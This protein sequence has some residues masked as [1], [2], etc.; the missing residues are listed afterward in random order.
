METLLT[1]TESLAFQS[2]LTSVD[3][4]QPPND[5]A[6][7]A[8]QF[9]PNSLRRDDDEIILD[10]APHSPPDNDPLT[11][12]T[13]DLMSL[14]APGW[15]NTSMMSGHSQLHHPQHPQQHLMYGSQHMQH[16]QHEQQHQ[17]LL[18]QPLHRQRA[19]STAHDSFPFLNQ[20]NNFQAS[21]SHFQQAP[22]HQAYGHPNQHQLNQQQSLNLTH[23]N[24][25]KSP[26]EF[27]TYPAHL[28]QSQ[29]QPATNHATGPSLTRSQSQGSSSALPPKRPIRSSATARTLPSPNAASS[30]T[31]A[32][33][34][35]RVA[36]ASQ[37][38]QT[39]SSQS[40]S[41]RPNGGSTTASGAA[42][43]AL[44]SPSQKK[45]NHIQSEQKRRANIR[46]GYEALC[47]TVP[48]LRE[49]IREEEEEMRLGAANAAAGMANGKGKAAGKKRATKKKD[50]E[51][52]VGSSARDKIDGRAGPRSENVVLSKTID[53][54]NDLL[55]ERTNLLSRL[56]RARSMLPPGHPGLIPLSPNPPWEREWKGGEGKFGDEEEEAEE[57]EGDAEVDED[58]DN[59]QMSG[60]KGRQKRNGANS[61]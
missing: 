55:S 40:Q 34:Q 29:Q 60:T 21:N 44:L 41:P 3:T 4:S 58:G 38:Q 22:Q 20:K 48:A 12:A 36:P 24:S 6:T 1:P 30:S 37:Q 31:T 42:K 50:S 14:D 59:S 46:R 57:S 45:A 17:S 27:F 53:Y 23:I 8:S 49:A 35:Q 13:K 5:W 28:R 52:G 47:E 19:Y 15:A 18:T 33:R 25:P 26:A 54:L 16:H 32:S 39:R 51:D 2:F 10:S 11:K 7:Y 43:P 56:Q 61:G 9:S